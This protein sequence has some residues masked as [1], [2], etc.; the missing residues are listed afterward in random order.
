[1]GLNAFSVDD[2]NVD[3]AILTLTHSTHSVRVD[4]SLLVSDLRLGKGEWLNVIGY[5]E[6]IDSQWIIKAIMAWPVSPGFNLTHYENTVNLR[7]QSTV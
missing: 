5:L 7:M 6:N 3:N 2:Y 1:M 4:V